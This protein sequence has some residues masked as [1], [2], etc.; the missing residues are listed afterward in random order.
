MKPPGR[1]GE[2]MINVRRVR[3]P[4]DRLLAMPEEERVFFLRIGNHCNQI[5]L[6]ARLLWYSHNR[7]PW[8]IEMEKNV[9]G[10]QSHQLARYDI[11]IL[12]EAWLDLKRNCHRG[13]ALGK[14]YIPKLSLD[15]TAALQALEGQFSKSGLLAKIR[16][17]SGF[18]HLKAT[19]LEAGFQAAASDAY[20]DDRW[21]V[22][23]GG[24]NWGVFN[25]ASELA[26]THAV[27]RLTGKADP[28]KALG[29]IMNETSN[30][31]S[32][33]MTLI[34]DL[35]NLIIQEYI[36]DQIQ[37]ETATIEHAPHWS[38]VYIPMVVAVDERQAEASAPSAF[39]P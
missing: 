17:E 16:N 1:K 35:I 24:A 7:P 13:N 34:R 27:L 8:S 38:E 18:H 2:K 26:V 30:A 11:G 31:S 25:E 12:H 29:Q 3:F 37:I 4:K 9:L 14:K 33:L 36:G 22:F 23:E 6:F 28:D 5:S 20:F 39:T 10:P 15:G 21:C 19:D 32:S